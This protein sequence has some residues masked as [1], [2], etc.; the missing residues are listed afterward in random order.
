MTSLAPC[1]PFGPRNGSRSVRWYLRQCDGRHHLTLFIE[2][3]QLAAV[4]PLRHAVSKKGEECGKL[5]KDS[6]AGIV[7]LALPN[8]ATGSILAQS[9]IAMNNL[10]DTKPYKKP[11][12]NHCDCFP[13]F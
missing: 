12:S 2:Q 3:R 8:Q 9:S 7:N 1:V 10:D 13:A 6:L 11:G 5:V 4:R